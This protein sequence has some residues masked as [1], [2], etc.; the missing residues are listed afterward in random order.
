ML[1]DSYIKG[2]I[3]ADYEFYKKHHIEFTANYA[4]IGNNIFEDDTWISKPEYSGYGLG[5]G[6]ETVIGPIELKHS[7]S[8]ETHN[9]FTWF[10]GG[11]YF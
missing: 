1:G 5:Y 2:S 8:P 3:V 9:H 10:T 6:Y 11:F 4:N 7:W